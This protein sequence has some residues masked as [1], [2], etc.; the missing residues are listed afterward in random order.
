MLSKWRANFCAIS[1]S[2]SM[3]SSPSMKWDCCMFDLSLAMLECIL[4]LRALRVFLSSV[5]CLFIK[6]RLIFLWSLI[7]SSS[8]VCMLRM[9]LG[10][11]VMVIDLVAV[12]LAVWFVDSSSFA[13]RSSSF[14]ELMRKLGASVVDRVVAYLSQS[15]FS[16]IDYLF[17]H[18]RLFRVVRVGWWSLIW[19]FRTAKECRYWQSDFEMR[20]RSSMLFPLG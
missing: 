5:E 6:V 17:V 13:A 12:F 14:V 19:Q 18:L 1:A 10:L 9:A 16:K 8:S 7:I 2:V 3:I 20:V 11:A 4:F 15:V